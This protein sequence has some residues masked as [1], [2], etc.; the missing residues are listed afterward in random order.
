MFHDRT[1]LFGRTGFEHN[2]GGEH[3]VLGLIASITLTRLRIH[4][5]L[6]GANDG[7]EKSDV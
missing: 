3:E 4:Q 2:F 6:I 5:D 7:F 1:D